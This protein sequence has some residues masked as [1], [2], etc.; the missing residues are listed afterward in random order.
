MIIKLEA[1]TTLALLLTALTYT[2][3]SPVLNRKRTCPNEQ[4]C[5]CDWDSRRINCYL[6]EHMLAAYATAAAP[7]FDFANKSLVAF[8]EICV[9]NVP[10]VERSFFHAAQFAAKFKLSV[11]AVRML[12]RH[13]A[14]NLTGLRH[15]EV[16]YSDLRQVDAETFDHMDCKSIRVTASD[17]N[18]PMNLN[19][20]GDGLSSGSLLLDFN[21]LNM[22]KSVF[23]N[24]D[25]G[26]L[27]LAL[28]KRF[29]SN[30]M[31][32]GGGVRR[33][34]SRDE[35]DVAFTREDLIKHW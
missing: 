4:Y 23:V 5:S 13:F 22:L 9:S 34:L 19:V 20:F 12:G 25:V 31:K 2:Q 6:A 29:N 28:K 33:N 32:L 10:R 35:F 27:S 17:K 24:A 16:A 15:L 3:A 30:Y 26:W 8:T 7:P 18:W 14:A 21:N 1:L 11:Q